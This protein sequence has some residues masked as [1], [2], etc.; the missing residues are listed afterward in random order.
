M[1]EETNHFWE[2]KSRSPDFFGVAIRHP[3]G[4]SSGPFD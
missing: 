1:P 3:L 2:F 4:A